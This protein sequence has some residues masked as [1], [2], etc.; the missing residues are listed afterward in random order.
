MLKRDFFKISTES[1][2]NSKF[3][4]FW[5]ILAFLIVGALFAY[6]YWWGYKKPLPKIDMERPSEIK[7]LEVPAWE[8]KEAREEETKK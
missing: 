5:I 6:D 7:S 4:I 2:V 3:I 1:K 8:G